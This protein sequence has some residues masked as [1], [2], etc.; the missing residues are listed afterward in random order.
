MLHSLVAR[1]T[2]FAL[3]Q[4]LL[5][6]PFRRRRELLR[7]RFAPFRPSDPRL[8]KWEQVP[9]CTDND[10]EKVKEFFDETLKVSSVNR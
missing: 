2:D 4:S 8:A 6:E 3:S 7:E 5:G 9:S 1:L 10:I